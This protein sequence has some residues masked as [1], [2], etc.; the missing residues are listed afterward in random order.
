MNRAS[1]LKISPRA[2]RALRQAGLQAGDLRGS[3]PAG[4]IIE[5]DV[6]E[7]RGAHSSQ[8]KGKR[9]PVSA[10]RA[11][12]A[13]RLTE[14]KQ[15]VPHFYLKQTIRADALVA[16]RKQVKE[17]TGAS[18]NDLLLQAVARTL[19][20]FP[21][22][23]C[24]WAGDAVEEQDGVHLGV[25][26]GLEEGGVAVP[27]VLNADQLSL[28][29]LRKETVRLS[30]S[31]RQRRIENMG[32]G[33]FTVSNLGMFGIEEFTAIVNPPES[34]ILAVGAIRRA[35][36]ETGL[37]QVM[38]VQLS[39]DHRII[40]GML[41][42]RFIGRLK[43]RLE[44]PATGLGERASVRV[45]ME[46]PPGPSVRPDGKGTEVIVV[47]AGPAGYVAALEA[48]HHGAH[49]TIV[50]K[51]DHLGGTCLNFGCIPSK[52][53]LASA[54]LMHRMEQAQ[55]LGIHL[56]GRPQIDWPAIQ[57]RK[58]KIVHELR[59]GIRQLLRAAK[60]GTEM[61][62]AKLAGPGLVAVHSP[63]GEKVLRASQIILAPGSRPALLPGLTAD[64]VRVGTTD[65]ALHWESL[66]SSL[67]IIGGGVIG[68]E[69]ACLMQALG[70]QV[71]V[72]EKRPG[73]LSEMDADLGKEMRQILTR[74]GNAD[75][76]TRGVEFHLGQ[77]IE[78][79]KVTDKDVVVRLGGGKEIR[80]E[81]VLVAVGRRPVTEEL[82]LAS[83][84]LSTQ[85][86]YLSVGEDMRA[87]PGIFCVGDANGRC[88]LAQAASAQGKVAA[89]N[90][91]GGRETLTGPVPFAVYSFPEIASVG[92]TEE[93]C[94]QTGKKIAV[95]RFS[96]SGLGK[97]RVVGETAGFVKVIRSEEDHSLL[98]VHTL[99]HNAVEFIT[100][101]LPLVRQKARAEELGSLI[102]P[103]PSM[104]ESLAEA[105]DDSYGRAL[106]LP[107]RA[108][109]AS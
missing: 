31:A 39:C 15:T 103:H 73:I 53:L 40:D 101:A 48:A 3:G 42:A 38:T 43:E 97:A 82:G 13:R 64:G 21:D 102:F 108:M 41:A 24:R 17:S 54:E 12:V 45:S 91:V 44:N 89:R 50:E 47:G 22:F 88:Q 90:A 78:K 11:A 109:H 49:V 57:N 66:P 98:G 36:T 107:M 4:R 46:P 81:R 52:A 29:E 25:A 86:G 35:M 85:N 93:E 55:T 23:L 14:S 72:V 67:L 58:N 2:R 10:M 18:V 94:R 61:G 27:V 76:G 87:G 1:R 84:G 100:A 96:L 33:V 59:G 79:V 30:E 99:G 16:F 106:H 74:R 8:S 65:T 95:G 26:V 60:V 6:R 69:F 32:R 77:E 75:W 92:L 70:V 62:T 20:E 5:K 68:V 34:G 83:V 28:A 104:S 56:P 105:A 63:A 9:R 19:A 7:A 51:S 80:A 37:A 71:H